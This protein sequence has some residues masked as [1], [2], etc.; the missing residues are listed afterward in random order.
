MALSPIIWAL[1]LMRRPRY[2]AVYPWIDRKLARFDRF[3]TGLSSGTV[4]LSFVVLVL[5]IVGLFHP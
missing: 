1:V 2:L 3:V 4:T 5:L